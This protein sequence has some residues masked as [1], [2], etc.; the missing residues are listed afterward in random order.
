MS[1]SGESQKYADRVAARPHYA[2]FKNRKKTLREAVRAG[3]ITEEE[4]AEKQAAAKARYEAGLSPQ[5]RLARL[6]AQA[7]GCTDGCA[8]AEHPVCRCRCGG[9]GHGTAVV[10]HVPDGCCRWCSRELDGEAEHDAGEC[11]RCS[12]ARWAQVQHSDLSWT[13]TKGTKL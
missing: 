5:D 8:R 11:R 12:L 4:R 6:A 10:R 13:E 1:R 2:R 7:Y 9:A 3:R